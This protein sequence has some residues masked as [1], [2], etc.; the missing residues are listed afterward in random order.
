MQVD[1][2]TTSPP[3][4]ALD[5]IL[6]EKQLLDWLGIASATAS[7]W[8]LIGEGP[9]FVQLGPRRIGYRRSAIEHGRKLTRSDTSKSKTTKR[10][11]REPTN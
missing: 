2:K 5:P 1:G 4:V 11:P 9:P 8:R 6:S 7:R 3:P 10:T